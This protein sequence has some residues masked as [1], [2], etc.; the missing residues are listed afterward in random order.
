MAKLQWYC[1]R[2]RTMD[3]S[4]ILHRVRALAWMMCRRNVAP[5]AVHVQP[6]KPWDVARPLISD[7]ARLRVLE[8]A[9]GY[10]D[11]RWF[12]FGLVAVA[13]IGIVGVAANSSWWALLGLMMGVALLGPMREVARGVSGLKLIPV[14]KQTGLAELLCAVGIFVGLMIAH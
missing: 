4:E 14:L 9:D 3:P 1:R 6:V 12:F 2:I 5:S 13:A 11:H 8:E 7:P 10:L